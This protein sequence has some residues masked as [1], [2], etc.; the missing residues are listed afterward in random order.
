MF[1]AVD[2]G[3]AGC[4]ASPTRSRDDARGDA[5]L[6]AEGL[7]VVMLTGDNRATAEAVARGSASTR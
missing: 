2:G 1:V 5:Q 7:R 3:L 6:R 4:S